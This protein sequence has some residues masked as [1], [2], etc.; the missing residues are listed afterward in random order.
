[1][2]QARFRRLWLPTLVRS[3]FI[4]CIYNTAAL[5]WWSMFHF[6][7]I[8]CLVGAFIV[9]NCRTVIHCFT[10]HVFR[11][12]DIQR[13]LHL[14]AKADSIRFSQFLCCWRPIWV[15]FSGWRL[16]TGPNHARVA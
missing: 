16:G 15:G 7:G 11:W 14:S 4:V 6:V 8:I 1:M 2:F 13:S 3:C 12:H 10:F 5:Q 9:I